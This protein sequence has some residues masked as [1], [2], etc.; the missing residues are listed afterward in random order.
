[1]NDDWITHSLRLISARVAKM[2]PHTDAPAQQTR[3]RDELQMITYCV[4]NRDRANT[5]TGEYAAWWDYLSQH[6]ALQ[7]ERYAGRLDERAF[8]ARCKA[9]RDRR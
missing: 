3:L 1:M 8:L 6:A 7:E 2:N 9:L 5:F 4:R